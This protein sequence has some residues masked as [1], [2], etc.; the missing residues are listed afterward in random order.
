MVAEALAA[1]LKCDAE[2]IVATKSR[3]GL[4]GDR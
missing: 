1:E 4:V 2:E 3:V